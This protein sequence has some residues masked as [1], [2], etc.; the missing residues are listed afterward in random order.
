MP[1]KISPFCSFLPGSTTHFQQLISPAWLGPVQFWI[2]TSCSLRLSVHCETNNLRAHFSDSYDLPEALHCFY[3][4]I[5][6]TTGLWR[7]RLKE[8][9][10][11]VRLEDNWKIMLRG[12]AGTFA[13]E[14]G[15]KEENYTSWRIWG[16]EPQ[17]DE[18]QCQK[19]T[20]TRYSPFYTISPQSNLQ[21]LVTEQIH[22][23]VKCWTII[24]KA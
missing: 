22:R 14:R 4:S 19:S 9:L 24:L 13:Y 15:L 11:K 23:I 1:S 2:Q 5:L 8:R 6:M 3:E 12:K 7:E 16:D 10:K 21:M 17:W 20:C 18:V